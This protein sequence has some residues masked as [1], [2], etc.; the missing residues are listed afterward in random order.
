[1]SA[2]TALIGGAF[3]IKDA[4]NVTSTSNVYRYC[5]LGNTGGVFYLENAPLF[6][7]GPSTFSYN[8]AV[9]GG[10][11]YCKGCTLNLQQS[12]ISNSQA[13]QGGVVYISEGATVTL[14]S[15][16]V[17][18]AYAS[19]TAGFLY[20]TETTNPTASITF[21]TGGTFNAVSSNGKAG[22]FYIDSQSMDILINAPI[23]VTNSKANVGQGGVFYIN[24]GR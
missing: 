14:K 7:S 24:R 3:F 19:N 8:A 23:T 18:T 15:I 9:K 4:V 6:D 20:A 11:F 1:M 2:Q 13:Y 21:V 16:S 22:A 17:S 12:S 10:V 5:Y